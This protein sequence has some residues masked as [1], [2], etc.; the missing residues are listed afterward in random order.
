[1]RWKRRSSVFHLN[2]VALKCV[3]FHSIF[4]HFNFFFISW[5]IPPVIW[6]DKSHLVRGSPVIFLPLTQARAYE[7]PR[8]YNR[9]RRN[10]KLAK[11]GK[12]ES[13]RRRNE[14]ITDGAKEFSKCQCLA[15]RNRVAAFARNF[16]SSGT[17]QTREKLL[18]FQTLERDYL[19]YHPTIINHY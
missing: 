18:L 5:I 15:L 1:M 10:L 9:W 2:F 12:P 7:R 11:W 17:E 6:K 13:E 3:C 8:A 4:S 14:K 16:S 19:N